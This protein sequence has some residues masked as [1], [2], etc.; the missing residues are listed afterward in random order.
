MSKVNVYPHKTGKQLNAV[1]KRA[2]D[3]KNPKASVKER[4]E[5]FKGTYLLHGYFTEENGKGKE[6]ETH[7]IAGKGIYFDKL[8]LTDDEV[9][10]VKRAN[11]RRLGNPRTGKAIKSIKQLENICT[12]A[13]VWTEEQA[14]EILNVLVHAMTSLENKLMNV[15]EEKVDAGFQMS[16]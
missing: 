8:E 7:I 15:K 9:L 1:E 11:F 3:K 6:V 4:K 5:A 10:E 14:H 12:P 16:E 13:Y 2:W